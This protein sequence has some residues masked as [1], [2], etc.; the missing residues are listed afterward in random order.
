MIAERVGKAVR[1]PAKDTLL[2]H[3]TAATGRGRG[4]AV[5][6]AM[7]QVGAL[8]GPLTVAGVLALSGNAYGPALGVLAAPGAAVP[9]LLFWQ[10]CA[11]RCGRTSVRQGAA[12]TIEWQEHVQMSGAGSSAG[13]AVQQEVGDHR[14]V[15]G[16]RGPGLVRGG[17]GDVR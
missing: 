15:I 9:A 1:S 5:H 11:E 13:P 6:E 14:A 3:A 8:V 17:D 7:D 12:W 16:G 10:G 2:S 4:F